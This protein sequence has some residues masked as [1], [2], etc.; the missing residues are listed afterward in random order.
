MHRIVVGIIVLIVLI[1]GESV[2]AQNIKV[3]IVV[4]NINASGGITTDRH[5]NIYVSDFGP[6]LGQPVTNT[7]VYK[8]NPKT[9]EFSV[10]AEGFSGASGNAFDSK[11]NFYQSN[12][13]SGNVSR[14]SATGEIEYQ[15]TDSTFGLPVGVIADQYDNMYVSNCTG[16]EIIKVTPDEEIS[17]YAKDKQFI[18]PNG[19]TIDNEGNL[20]SINFGTG[21]VFKINK[22]SEVEVLAEL[23]VLTGGPNPVGNGHGTWKNGFLFVT[24]IGR[25]E[26]Y[27][28]S[29]TGDVELVAGRA[30]AF[31]NIEG[32]ALNAGFSKPNGIAA[33]VTGDSLYVNVSELPWTSS[34]TALHPAHLMMISGVCSLED[35]VCKDEEK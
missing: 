35:V 25:G 19:L 15:W 28:I 16:A 22:D 14:V 26:V 17:R 6:A 20:Y 1:A 10:F 9:W 11:G 31:A 7:K 4:P 23:P 30:L 8:V 13:F 5:G 24:T 2:H 33:S 27:K 29:P 3:T 18:C 32:D 34:G 12:P 21:K